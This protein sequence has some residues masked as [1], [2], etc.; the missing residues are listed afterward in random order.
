MQEMWYKTGLL[1]RKLIVWMEEIFAW[2]HLWCFFY[3]FCFHQMLRYFFFHVKSSEGE[4]TG[5]FVWQMISSSVKSNHVIKQFR[6]DKS[7]ICFN[8]FWSFERRA[9]AS[10]KSN[11]TYNLTS[12]HKVSIFWLLDLLFFKLFILGCL[13]YNIFSIPWWSNNSLIYLYLIL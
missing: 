4:M 11:L 10:R 9:A 2:N 5:L 1:R 3:C 13:H 6:A 7:Y 12:S 8:L